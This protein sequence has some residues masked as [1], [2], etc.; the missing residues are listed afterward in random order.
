MSR[1]RERLQ[2]NFQLGISI[3]L[4]LML[5]KFI[6]IDDGW[7]QEKNDWSARRSFDKSSDIGLTIR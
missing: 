5:V 1:V 6:Y 2:A 3:G 4:R 7:K